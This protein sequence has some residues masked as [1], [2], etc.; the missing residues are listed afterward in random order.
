MVSV[1][2]RSVQATHTVYPYNRRRQ[3]PQIKLR[4]GTRSLMGRF[5]R[6]VRS[7]TEGSGAQGGPGRNER[8][9]WAP[10]SF[11]GW[12]LAGSGSVL[13]P[14]I[15]PHLRRRGLQLVGRGFL[16][17]FLGDL[18]VLHLILV[19][20]LRMFLLRLVFGLGLRVGLALLHERIARARRS[21]V[22]RRGR[23][24]LDALGR[25][26]LRREVGARLR[27]GLRKSGGCGESRQCGTK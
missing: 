11:S 6:A 26:R 7:Q 19:L 10:V 17:R 13:R 12:Q 21:Q 14:L 22:L 1:G 9:R 18:R 20:L 8:A 16:I 15:G 2:G 27:G 23:D 25:R 3:A 4:G 24:R 5:A